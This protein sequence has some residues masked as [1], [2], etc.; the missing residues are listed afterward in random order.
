MSDSTKIIHCYPSK[1]FKYW[2]RSWDYTAQHNQKFVNF[3]F[4]NKFNGHFYF[5]AILFIHAAS[6]YK[7]KSLLPIEVPAI[8]IKLLF[9]LNME[10]NNNIS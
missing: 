3:F 6:V 8:I 5:N 9:N 1:K 10:L 4:Y 7:L 2:R